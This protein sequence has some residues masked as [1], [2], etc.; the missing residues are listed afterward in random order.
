[1]IPRPDT[2]VLVEVALEHLPEDTELRIADIGTG[3][4]AVALAL[5]EERPQAHLL[6]TDISREALELASENAG[7]QELDERIDFEAGDLLEAVPEPW[8]PLDAVVCN[9]PYVAE[10]D[11]DVEIDVRDF[12]PDRA[13]FAG[14]EGLDVIER[15]VPQAF[16]ALKPGGWLFF[17]IG[18]RQGEPAR[19]LLEEAGFEDVAIRTDYGDRDRVA[20]GRRPE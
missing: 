14:P 5:A 6:A 7:R 10:E 13:L 8:R 15:L 11:P 20:V 4:G 12:E 18:Y 3:S 2:E 19:R 16:A 17:E 1:L 9:P